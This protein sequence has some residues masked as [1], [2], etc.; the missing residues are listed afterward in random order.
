[1]S[2]IKNGQISLYSHFNKIIKGPGTT[3][4]SPAFSQKHVRTVFYTAYQYLTKFYFDSTQD[5]KEISISSTSIS[6]VYDDVTD[7]E[8]CEFHKNT[9]IQISRKRELFFLQMKKFINYT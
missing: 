6:N 5:S 1:M 3:F 9:K 2:T 8:I 4:Q 7:F